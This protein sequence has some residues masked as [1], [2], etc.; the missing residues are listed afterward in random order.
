M[1]TVK[2][3]ASKA[4]DDTVQMIIRG[5]PRSVHREFKACCAA[6][7][8]TIRARIIETMKADVLTNTEYPRPYSADEN[9]KKQQKEHLTLLRQHSKYSK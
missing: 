5:V 3:M 7:G 2:K 1:T 9:F 6:K 4:E 8:K